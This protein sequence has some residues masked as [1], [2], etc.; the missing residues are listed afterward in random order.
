MTA[1][2][3]TAPDTAPG[4]LTH[5][6]LTEKAELKYSRMPIK[7]SQHE[8]STWW[9]QGLINDAAFIFLALKIERVGADGIEDFD[10]TKFCDDWVGEVNGKD[11]RLKEKTVMKVIQDLQQKGAATVD[12][13]MQLSL[14]V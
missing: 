13:S 8:L 7:V 2:L 11:K 6:D 5:E 14:D 3:T 9:C 4:Q 12:M 1:T 10:I